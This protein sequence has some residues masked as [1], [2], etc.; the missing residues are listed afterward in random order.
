MKS[1]IDVLGR[2][3]LVALLAVACQDIPTGVSPMR[4]PTKANTTAERELAAAGLSVA[5]VE[6]PI[7]CDYPGAKCGRFAY[8]YAINDQGTVVG[9]AEFHSVLDLYNFDGAVWPDA[10]TIQRVS[11]DFGHPLISLRGIN[12]HGDLLGRPWASSGDV[13]VNGH[14]IE[15]PAGYT[16]S[17][18]VAINEQSEVIAYGI[19]FGGPDRAFVWTPSGGIRTLEYH[20]D[21]TSTDATPS[22]PYDI[23]DDGMV[24]GTVADRGVLWDARRGGVVELAPRFGVSSV[25]PKGINNK[26]EI[27]GSLTGYTGGT[28][29]SGG[30]FWSPTSGLHVIDSRSANAIN[31]SSVVVGDGYIWTPRHGRLTLVLP[32]GGWAGGVIGGKINNRN[33]IPGWVGSGGYMCCSRAARFDIQL[34]AA[35]LPPS[36]NIG[37]AYNGVEGAAINFDGS[38]SSDPE[39]QPLSFSWTFG[40][41]STAMTSTPTHTYADNGSYIVRFIVTDAL[42]A[43]DTA[44]TTA[45]IENVPPVAHLETPLAIRSGDS[46]VAHLSFSDA[47]AADMPWRYAIDWSVGAP[48]EGTTNAQ[49]DP[50]LETSPR[51]CAAGEYAVRATVTD[52]DGGTGTTST[53]LAVNRIG[54]SVDVLTK[55]INARAKGVL[56][57][58]I[59][60]TSDLDVRQLDVESIV[61]G[62]GTSPGVPVARHPNGSAASSLEDLNGDGRPDLLLHFDR[63]LFAS[64]AILSAPSTRL[65][66]LGRY[67]DG[68]R[69]VTGQEE[70]RVLAK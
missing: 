16:A 33:Q 40:D 65:I 13:F 56:P 60:G 58:A 30:F 67:V 23:N 47:G 70:V 14:A 51:Y 10:G 38:A 22:R 29:S 62:N 45:T 54:I 7:H 25:L 66:L 8:G 9:T 24:V 28:L 11:V 41:G 5:L 3:G 21:A 37:G 31:D 17:T 64:N 69:E 46:F 15:Q 53:Q 50:I 68:C 32:A 27:V 19:I 39:G 34:P 12:N 43:S 1:V 52:K 42:G 6:L 48:F 61:L 59:L 44:T 55:T 2:F 57:V 63:E 20:L 4:P 18:P 36:A 49:S 35:N 26:G